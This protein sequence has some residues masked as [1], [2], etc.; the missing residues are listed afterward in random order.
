METVETERADRSIG[1]TVPVFEALDLLSTSD[2]EQMWRDVDARKDAT[3]EG[4][5]HRRRLREIRDRG[6]L[7]PRPDNHVGFRHAEASPQ[8]GEL[9]LGALRKILGHG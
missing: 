3:P 4:A 9:P 2:P 7:L 8:T 6:A 1:E 5:G